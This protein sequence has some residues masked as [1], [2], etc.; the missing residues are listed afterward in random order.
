MIQERHEQSKHVGPNSRLRLR[1]RVLLSGVVGGG[2]VIAF[3]AMFLAAVA[4]IARALEMIGLMAWTGAVSLVAVAVAALIL[5]VLALTAVLAVA[6]G[7]RRFMPRAAPAREIPADSGG[8]EQI[9][10]LQTAQAALDDWETDGGPAAPPRRRVV[11]RRARRSNRS[12]RH[13]TGAAA[14]A[15]ESRD[16][17]RSA[18]PLSRSSSG[19]A[20]CFSC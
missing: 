8:D 18:P 6:A 17:P 15:V 7:V 19:K 1:T 16:A 14:A 9:E 2:A 11:W 13:P 4:F 20:S 10:E 12:D 5:P 3:P